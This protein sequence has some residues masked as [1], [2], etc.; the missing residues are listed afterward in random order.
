MDQA[1]LAVSEVKSRQAR[2]EGMARHAT[3]LQ[4]AAA[5]AADDARREVDELLRGGDGA[6]GG[7]PPLNPDSEDA[8]AL[9]AQRDRADSGADDV[10]QACARV[11][12]FVEECK[13]LLG[14]AQDCARRLALDT[15]EAA[16]RREQTEVQSQQHSLLAMLRKDSY[17]CALSS[18]PFSRAWPLFPCR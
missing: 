8:K 5:Q 16:R 13:G 15:Q 12:G 18:D 6:P 17:R 1:D 14:R 9:A 10:A 4:G 2:I 3:V 11:R 7:V